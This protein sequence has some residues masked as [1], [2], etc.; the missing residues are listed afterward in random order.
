V[1]ASSCGS[2]WKGEIGMVQD[3]DCRTLELEANCFPYPEPLG[4][5]E[6]EVKVPRAVEAVYREIADCARGWRRH[7][8]WLECRRDSL[9][10]CRID[11]YVKEIRVDKEHAGWCLE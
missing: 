9:A 5:S 4:N 6:V 3:V 2:N 7:Q 10:G 11:G 8:T 1:G